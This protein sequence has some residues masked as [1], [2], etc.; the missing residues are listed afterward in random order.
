V[1]K[2]VDKPRIPQTAD[3]ICIDG[4]SHAEV[5][6][7]FNR[8]EVFY[9]YDEAS[10]YSQYAAICGCDSVVVPGLYPSRADWVAHHPPARFGV[11]YG[12]DDLEHARA[13]RHLVIDQLR[14]QEAA[15]LE[16]VRRFISLTEAR[17]R[18]GARVSNLQKGS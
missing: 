5:A 15:G 7:I 14:A 9:S 4:M 1:R 10:F 6:V 12:L 2:G 11:A 8:C 18:T 16:T 3:A 13:T 17:F